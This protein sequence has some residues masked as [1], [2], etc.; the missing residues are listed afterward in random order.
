MNTRQAARRQAEHITLDGGEHST[1]LTTVEDVTLFDDN[2]TH[3]F[4]I[5]CGRAVTHCDCDQP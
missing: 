2:Y 3:V 1:E 5:A 4:C